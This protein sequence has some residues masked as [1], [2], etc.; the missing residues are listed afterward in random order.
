MP[1]RLS[2][3]LRLRAALQ[4]GPGMGAP[5]RLTTTSKC[6]AGS[7]CAREPTQAARPSN[8]WAATRGL[9]A[10]IVTRWPLASS[11]RT[12]A[13]PIKPVPPVS[14]NDCARRAGSAPVK[15]NDG[16]A[17]ARAASARLASASRTPDAATPSANTLSTQ[18]CQPSGLRCRPDGSCHQACECQAS[19]P[20]IT[21]PLMA[22]TVCVTRS[23]GGRLRVWSSTTKSRSVSR[24][25]MA[26]M[27]HSGT[28][29][30]PPQANHARPPNSTPYS[31]ARIACRRSSGAALCCCGKAQR[32]S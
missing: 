13:W 24:I 32:S 28:S 4:R 25:S 15:S 26:T 5:A 2:T 20:K 16:V 27:A 31:T 29:Q 21:P 11:A 3:R 17:P 8:N 22:R 6:T 7:I 19:K 10:Q 9:R 14:R 18:L 23:L 1:T 30:A 12:S